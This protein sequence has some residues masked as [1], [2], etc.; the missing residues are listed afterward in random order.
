MFVNSWIIPV[1]YPLEVCYKNTSN[2]KYWLFRFAQIVIHLGFGKQ[3]EGNG[4]KVKFS[5]EILSGSRSRCGKLTVIRWGKKSWGNQP[6]HPGRGPQEPAGCSL[7]GTSPASLEGPVESLGL[8]TDAICQGPAHT[9]PGAPAA[10]PWAPPAV[11]G[12]RSS[13]RDAASLTKSILSYFNSGIHQKM[14]PPPAAH[15]ICTFV[16]FW[17]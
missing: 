17:G 2:F 4:R 16:L 5:F 3:K 10:P 11:Q 13:K 15:P 6:P 14:V 8:S 7:G 12:F 9:Y 1:V